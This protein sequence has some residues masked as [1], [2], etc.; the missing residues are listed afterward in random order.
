MVMTAIFYFSLVCFSDMKAVYHEILVK[1]CI[2]EIKRML[3]DYYIYSG[4]KSGVGMLWILRKQAKL[5]KIFIESG[6]DS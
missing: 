2:K 4:T 6:F 1:S 5:I 3:T